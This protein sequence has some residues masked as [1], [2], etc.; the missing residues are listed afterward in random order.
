MVPKEAYLAPLVK[1]DKVVCIG[2]NY[3]DHCE[4]QGAPIPVE[5]IVF[6]KWSSCITGPYADIQCTD[7]TQVQRARPCRGV[8]EE[9]F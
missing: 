8:G 9:D 1:P 2:M 4:E 3:K 5:P 6:S 7:E